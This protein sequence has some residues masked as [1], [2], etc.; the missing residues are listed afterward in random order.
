MLRF[1]VSQKFSELCFYTDCNDE[2]QN[3]IDDAI[4]QC[5]KVYMYC[6]IKVKRWRKDSK[7]LKFI[8][9]FVYLY[10]YKYKRLLF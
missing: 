7:Y 2:I 5:K 9:E 4:M 8:L 10:L 3:I 1:T 6:G